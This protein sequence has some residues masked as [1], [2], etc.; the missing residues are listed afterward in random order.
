MSTLTPDQ[1]EALEQLLQFPPIF[2]LQGYAGTGKTFLLKHYIERAEEENRIVITATTHKALSVAEGDHT[3]HSY[4]GLK[5]RHKEN[6]SKYELVQEGKHQMQYNDIVI[7]DEASMVS[8]E[9]LSFILK[10]QEEYDLT[11]VF[12]GDPAQLPPVEEDDSP[13]WELEA[14]F[15]TLRE[16]VR[17]AKD[18]NIIKLATLIREGGY[19]RADILSTVD[20]KSVFSGTIKQGQEFFVNNIQGNIFPQ[21]LS[22]RNVVVNELN[23]WA[24][25][26]V[27]G[28]DHSRDRY[29]TEENLYIRTAIPDSPFR[30]EDIVT[31]KEVGLPRDY[32]YTATD[33]KVSVIPLTVSK[34]GTVKE[35]IVPYNNRDSLNYQANIKQ[36]A[37]YAKKKVT[38]WSAFWNYAESLIEVKHIYAMTVHRSQ[39]STFKDIV[40]NKTDINSDRLFYTAVTRASERVFLIL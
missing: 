40:V 33:H 6:S 1:Q 30:L 36:L 11:I 31:V 3:I 27:V 29:L 9:I 35:I 22:F 17:Q 20:N 26:Q 12:V 8:R 28:E 32:P 34:G 10:A 18:S 15:Y 37:K 13:V 14:P 25:R 39:G 21:I 2:I 7:I 5:L 38:T 4:L 24:R 16:I 23:T 19:T